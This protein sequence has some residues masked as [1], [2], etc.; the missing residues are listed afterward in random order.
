MPAGLAG[1]PFAAQLKALREATGFTQEELAT[2]SGLSVHAVSALER[3]QRRRP[4]P[5]T[6]RALATALELAPDQRDALLRTARAKPVDDVDAWAA[7]TL[8]PIPTVL[9][10]RARDLETV[11]RWLANSTGRLMTLLGPGGVG[12]TRLALEAA[13]QAADAGAM[14]VVFV[15]LAALRDA[16]FVTS[17]IAEAFGATDATEADLI[18]RVGAACANT[19]A[20]LVLDNCEH[21]LDAAPLVARL[22]GAVRGLRVLATSR[23]PLRIRGEREYV[24]EPLPVEPD[25]AA[26]ASL[27]AALRLF[28]DR[29]H[30]FDPEFV[31]AG[32][33]VPVAAAICRRLDALP[34]AIELAAPWL[35]VLSAVELLQRLE[36]DVL[37]PTVGRRDLPARQQTMNATVAW[38]YQLLAADEQRAFRCL[39]VLPGAFPIDAAAAVQTGDRATPASRAHAQTTVAGLIERSLLV[40][41]EQSCST[42]P[43]Y[44]MLETVRAYAAAQLV[45]AGECDAAMEGLSRYA[46]SVAIEAGGQ[47]V[48]P[49]Q[50][51]WLDRVR[52][53]LETFRSAMRWLVEHDRADAA[54]D[55]AFHLL[56]F[57]LIRGHA[58]EGL[59]WYEQIARLESIA[60]ATRAR[61]LAGAGVMLYSLGEL[62]RAAEQCAR[63]LT[64]VDGATTLAAAVAE[65]TL[66]H[67]SLANSEPLVARSR[68]SNAARTFEELR[69]DWGVGNATAGIAGA[70][71]RLGDVEA[72][73]RRLDEA[74]TVLSTTG[75][76]FLQIVLY[77]RA[78]LAVRQNRPDAAVAFIRDSL[79]LIHALHDKFALVYAL[80]PLAAAA[81]LAG[82]EA[83]AARIL[84][85][86][87]AVT[88]RT[89]AMA[90]GRSVWDVQERIERA[91]R[92]RLGERRWA[93]EYDAGRRR[94]LESLLKEVEERCAMSR[95][96]PAAV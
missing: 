13:R 12:K 25:P 21:V 58:A 47:L 78:L 77:V 6:V 68:F 1:S 71:L 26:D 80:V 38:S 39:G 37:A 73:E 15:E 63:S 88:E 5:E 17:A 7:P 75:P 50:G 2:I 45:A 82:D 96:A 87:D 23:A 83:W 59:R 65:N 49:A 67:I 48:G 43:L 64:I 34:L 4:Q 79:A 60:P 19:Q 41:V 36:R 69:I 51:L 30:D 14:R 92:M 35:K 16:S 84:G 76:W 85:T 74:T 94:S 27:P 91:A 66:G 44:R 86:R 95:D 33:I 62:D 52:D 55:V 81:Q 93:R 54:C 46:L 22:V 90:A 18:R 31:L 42:R 28:A 56:F 24:V 72:A 10:G 32:D 40:C 53:D 29:I 57:W 11:N 8:P 3:G 70:A 20:L 9:V 61:A 89:G